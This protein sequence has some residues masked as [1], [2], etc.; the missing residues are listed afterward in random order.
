MGCEVKKH[1]EYRIYVSSDG[2][3][4][5]MS[6]RPKKLTKRPD[7]YLVT[8]VGGRDMPIARVHR[9]VLE[10]FVGPSNGMEVR[11][12]DGNPLNNVVS[13]LAWGTRK[14]QIADQKA[15][16]TFVPP[17]RLIGNANHHY[18]GVMDG[19]KMAAAIE[20][21]VRTDISLRSVSAKHAVSRTHMSR[22][23]RKLGVQKGGTGP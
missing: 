9:L 14:E 21:Y 2:L 22:Q 4:Y 11:H 23:L 15:H 18:R 13:N 5:D 12:I 16:G 8:S 19:P 17:P 10:T 20:E 1:P 6:M 3:I 7:G